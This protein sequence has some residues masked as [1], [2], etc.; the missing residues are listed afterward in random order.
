MLLGGFAATGPQCSMCGLAGEQ[1]RQ[2]RLSVHELAV[3]EHEAAPSDGACERCAVES[4]HA[5]V[6]VVVAVAVTIRPLRRLSSLGACTFLRLGD[7]ADHGSSEC[8]MILPERLREFE[9]QLFK[10]ATAELVNGIAL[11]ARQR[12]VKLD[13]AGLEHAQ[14][15]RDKDRI[16]QDLLRLVVA[17]G[18]RAGCQH[19]HRPATAGLA[20]HPRDLLYDLSVSDVEALRHALRHR[21]PAPP[22]HAMLPAEGAEDFVVVPVVQAEGSELLRASVLEVGQVPLK[23]PVNDVL[24]LVSDHSLGHDRHPVGSD[25]TLLGDSRCACRRSLSSL[26]RAPIRGLHLHGTARLGECVALR[27]RARLRFLAHEL[28]HLHEGCT[29][30]S[31]PSRAQCWLQR[32]VLRATPR[33]GVGHSPQVIAHSVERLKYNVVNG[34]IDL[35]AVAR[36][37]N[38]QRTLREC[39]HR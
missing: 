21:R 34:G 4:F 1:R 24:D 15:Y 11:R 6:S 13:R 33:S 26:T 38:G 2:Y 5:A 17:S 20:I 8:R 37:E 29:P 3:P 9:H 19:A 22:D 31:H 25:S 18:A 16:A 36:V 12:W 28:G 35:L 7:H 27:L 32:G 14:W 10:P 23:Q 30:A 39:M